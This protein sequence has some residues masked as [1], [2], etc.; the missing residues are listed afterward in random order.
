MYTC[1]YGASNLVQNAIFKSSEIH[2]NIKL[3]SYI[4]Q[5]DYKNM[6]SSKNISIAD[7]LSNISFSQHSKMQYSFVAAEAS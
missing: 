7:Y 2:V 3:K 6:F 5:E 1:E 4:L